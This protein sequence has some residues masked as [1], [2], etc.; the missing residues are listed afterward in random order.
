[1]N[2]W[3]ITR[4]AF[5]RILATKARSIL[6]MLG[7]IIG[8]ASL[9]ALTSI[10]A[11]A[12]SGI[13]SSLSSLGAKQITVSSSSQT[14]LT[15][16][17]AASLKAIS[18]V[19]V[20]STRVSG[21][22]SA[23]NGTTQTTISLSGVSPTYKDTAQPKIAVG[24]FL[25]ETTRTKAVVLSARGAN[26]LSF[27]AS[28]IGE[29]ILIDGLPFTVVGVLNDASGFGNAGTAYM[30]LDNARS[31]FAQ[32]PYVNSI[33]VQTAT[34][35]EVTNVQS[36]VDSLLRGRYGLSST[37]TAQFSTSNQASLLSTLSTIQS[38]LS[39]LLGGIASIS[40]V[41][42]GIG[43]MNIMLVSV[44]ERTREIGV[45]RAI[46]A[47]Q[48]QILAQFL[49]EA[50]VLSILGGI[51][52]LGLGLMVSAI[53]AGIAGWAFT[54]SGTTIGVALGFSALVGIVFGV[55]PALTAARLQPV[56]A[57]RYE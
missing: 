43:I 20:I 29:Q 48:R 37:D 17:D 10:A 23:A 26:E 18:G 49:I 39:L 5:S 42:G 35:G 12:T 56:E 7:V 27:T 33:T 31:I 53:I 25:P 13:N 51:I 28:Q 11:G 32:A 16:A 24:S 50:I 9:V 38:T 6:T 36:E 4:L 8:V 40:L 3:T 44:R 54:V 15:E 45:R 14:G 57:L 41:V 55:W 2:G 1:M 21:N 22:G 47:K 46:G 52:G 34:E 30:S 19:D